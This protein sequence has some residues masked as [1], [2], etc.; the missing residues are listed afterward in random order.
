MTFTNSSSEDRL[1]Q[2]TFAEH[3]EQALGRESPHR[4]DRRRTG[5]GASALAIPHYGIWYYQSID[6]VLLATS[7][8]RSP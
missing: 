1:V 6:W 5:A 3:L 8:P 2:Q 4:A 7:W